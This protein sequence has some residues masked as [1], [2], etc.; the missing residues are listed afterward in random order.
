MFR[1][2]PEL[3]VK[4]SLATNRHARNS[5]DNPLG[6]MV[7]C[8]P[9]TPFTMAAYSKLNNGLV[10]HGIDLFITRILDNQR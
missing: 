1:I 5:L 7:D 8:C 4:N 10:E 3:Q 2:T 9:Q 6:L